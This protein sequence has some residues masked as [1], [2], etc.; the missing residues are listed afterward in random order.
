M[1]I[2]AHSIFN[3]CY[4]YTC[5]LMHRAYL[6]HVIFDASVLLLIANINLTCLF[7]RGGLDLRLVPKLLVILELKL[8]SLRRL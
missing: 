2:N 4:I 7:V 8:S 3:T 5:T 1:Y 6:I